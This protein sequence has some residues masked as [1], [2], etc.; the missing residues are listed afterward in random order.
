MLPFCEPGD[1]DTRIWRSGGFSR[2]FATITGSLSS[3]GVL[4]IFG[5]ATIVL[6]SNDKNNKGKGNKKKNWRQFMSSKAFIFEIVSST[7]LAL[8]F[9]AEL[10]IKILMENGSHFYGYNI[11]TCTTS[12]VSWLFSLLMIYKERLS[13][14]FGL[15]H[16][17]PLVLFWLL[18]I[19]WLSL[20]VM[21]WSSSEWWWGLDDKIDKADLILFCIRLALLLVLC[22]VSVVRP[23]IVFKKR[24]NYRLI[25]NEI[26]TETETED[27]TPAKPSQGSEDP[28]KSGSFERKSS[29]GSAFG[30]FVKKAKLIF[31]YVWPKGHYVLQLV[32]VICFLILASGRVINLYVPI[33]YK[34]IVN[35]LTP[36]KNMTDSLDLAYGVTANNTGITF[37]LASILIYVGLRFLQGGAVGS[38]GFANNLRT[39]LWIKVQQYTSRAMQVRLFSHLHSLSLRWHL[40]RK[41]GEVLRV[42][43]RGTNSINN[44]LS[45]VLFNILPT[46][47]DIAIAVVYFI[48]AFDAWFG[49]IVF[50]TMVSYL[51]FTISITEWRTKY[52]RIMNEMDNQ[53]KAKGV[54]SLLNFETVKYYGHEDFEVER[55]K[56]AILNY[57]GAEWESLASLNL[58]NSGQNLIITSGLLVGS[59]LCAY[60]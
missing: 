29:Q 37:P 25:I 44:L 34:K 40:G 55:F 10:L 13:S 16:S 3:S 48:I 7:S 5:I 39:F 35:G 17:L 8:S 30:D 9:L 47:V 1:T 50:T 28:S 19:V 43:D 54:D 12:L 23:L 36:Q 20:S 38:M 33:Y 56:E 24:R 58:L 15:S 6:C 60:R 11:V 14:Y 42:M 18:N 53:V 51:L 59:M 22:T 49:L 52:R 46:I 32:V 4:I 57:Q 45:Y 27:E 31:P 2:C 21:S 41:T 26:E